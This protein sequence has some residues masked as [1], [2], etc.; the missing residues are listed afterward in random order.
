MLGIV[1]EAY[2]KCHCRVFQDSISCP[3]TAVRTQGKS[4]LPSWV[5]ALPKGWAKPMWESLAFT[6]GSLACIA[7]PIECRALSLT[8]HQGCCTQTLSCLNQAGNVESMTDSPS[9]C[10][11][12]IQSTHLIASHTLWS[13]CT[14]LVS[15]GIPRREVC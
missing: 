12:K 1:Q 11:F 13:S 10:C 5:I 4:G 8:I 6:G 3:I 9:A 15:T 14:G 2:H 7:Q